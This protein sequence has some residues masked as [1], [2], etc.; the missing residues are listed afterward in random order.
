M[1]QIQ[2][3]NY[4]MRPWAVVCPCL[5]PSYTSRLRCTMRFFLICAV[6]L[7]HD[8]TH[9]QSSYHHTHAHPT[10]KSLAAG[11]NPTSARAAVAVSTVAV[12]ALSPVTQTQHSKAETASWVEQG[13]HNWNT[14]I[15]QQIAHD[16]HFAPA[17]TPAA[18]LEDPGWIHHRGDLK[19]SSSLPRLELH[20]KAT[21]Q[22]AEVAA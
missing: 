18:P 14:I 16:L 22:K 4:H 15:W 19:N 10:Q 3:P 20:L 1:G 13:G 11:C 17:S 7:N 8:R 2:Q 6:N 5:C 21:S 9:T 12:V